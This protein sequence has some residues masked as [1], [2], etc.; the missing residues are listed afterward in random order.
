MAENENDGISFEEDDHRVCF[1][2]ISRLIPDANSLQ[3]AY[4][5]SA[6][7]QPATKQTA[8]PA[9]RRKVAKADAPSLTQGSVIEAEFPPLFN[10]A[11][12]P[13]AVR[14][15]KQLFETA[16]PV[17]EDRIQVRSRLDH[18]DCRVVY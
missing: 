5:F 6:G 17:L 2:S 9:K 18:D 4:I 15:R 13:D 8:R 12:S 10:G 16:W 14:V 3:A 11:E 7:T 1:F